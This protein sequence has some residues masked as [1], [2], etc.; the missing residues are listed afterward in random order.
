[1]SINTGPYCE[2]KLPERDSVLSGPER[3]PQNYKDQNGNW[4]MNVWDDTAWSDSDR[5]SIGLYPY[6]ENDTGSPGE[7]YDRSLSDFTIHADYVSRD[8]IYTQ[9][10]IEQVKDS[11]NRELEDQI[12]VYSHNDNAVNP[13]TV[14][15]VRNDA[16]WVADKQ[17]QLARITDWNEAAAFDT[18]KP[19]VLPLSNSYIGRSYVDQGVDLTAKNQASV[20]AGQGEIVP[21]AELNAFITANRNAADDSSNSTA[22]QKPGYRIRQPIANN[23]EQFNRII[24]WREA[25]DDPNPAL[26]TTYKMQ[27]RNR[28]DARDLYI[29]SYTNG[30]Y[31]TW[32][33][34]EDQGNGVWAL[35]A[36]PAE[37]QYVPLDMAFIFSYSTNPA[38]EAEYFTDRV[39]FPAGVSEKNILVAWDPV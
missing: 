12:T 36:T 4:N 34:F 25:R 37:W 19:Q 8:A 6:V 35:E 18:T 32:R 11:K 17:A 9:W 27:M 7:Y 28:Q 14:E 20:D 13:K 33:K 5:V 21:Q 10:P 26:R 15:Y 24:I 31:L 29:F 16:Q 22:P 23:S 39:E 3:L 2:V 38:V 30:T 1:M